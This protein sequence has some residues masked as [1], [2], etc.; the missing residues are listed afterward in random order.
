[1]RC[2]LAIWR[3]ITQNNGPQMNAHF[4]LV[5]H[6]QE[7]DGSLYNWFNN[8]ST[9]AS[10][11][12]WLAKDGTMEQYVDTDIQAWAQAAGNPNYLSVETEGFV[13]EPL[14]EL[15]LLAMSR[16]VQ[17]CR[18]VYDIPMRGPVPHGD[19]GLTPHCNPDGTPD[20]AW[21]N[22]PCP[23]TIRLEQMGQIIAIAK[24]PPAPPDLTEGDVID[25]EQINIAGTEYLVSN[26]V[27]KGQLV[28]VRQTL[29]SIGTPSNN[30]NTSIINLSA[31][32][33]SELSDVTGGAG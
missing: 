20:P 2:P 19:K 32:W 26:V 22:H 7:G 1:M 23:G 14:T 11:H 15:Q 5:L 17:W 33:P 16:L 31:Q 4:G 13:S 21:G 30:G 8:P 18:A 10:S 9:K 3:P 24:P 25:M 12:L 29:A 28:Q 27:A 6:V